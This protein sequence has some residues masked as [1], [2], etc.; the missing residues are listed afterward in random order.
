MAEQTL[1]TVLEGAVLKEIASYRF[2]TDLARSINDRVARDTF[3]ELAQQ[4]IGHRQFLEKYLR[5]EFKSGA[6]RLEHPVDYKIA[7]HLE[8]P[9]ITPEMK[10][11]DVFLLAAHREKLSHELYLGLARSHP[12][13]EVRGLLEGLAAQELKHKQRVEFLYTEVAFPQTDG[14]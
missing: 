10:M 2:Y 12:P 4:E 5:G 13:G 7:E 8:Q 11:K 1:K 14:G 9:E 6:L 3:N